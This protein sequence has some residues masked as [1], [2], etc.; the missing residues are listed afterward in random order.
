MAVIRTDRTKIT[1]QA[2]QSAGLIGV[3]YGVCSDCNKDNSTVLNVA[4][5]FL[6]DNY[7]H[8]NRQFDKDCSISI[9]IPKYML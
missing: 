2:A 6:H 4:N 9:M 8:L 7:D 1:I 3:C 5:Y